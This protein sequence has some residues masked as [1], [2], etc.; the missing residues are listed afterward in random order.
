MEKTI[1]F[2]HGYL[3]SSGIWESIVTDVKA[4]C[5]CLDLLGHGANEQDDF[6]SISDMSLD[7]LQ[8][9]QERRVSNY[10]VVGHSMGGYVA[11]DLMERDPCC[12]KIMLLNS[13]FWED[14]AGKKKDRL[15]VVEAVKHNKNRFL[16]E[17][18][19]N[20]FAHP[21]DHEEEV[22]LLIREAAMMSVEAIGNASLAMRSRS[23][24]TDLVRSRLK[25]VVVV[26][27]EMDAVMPPEDMRE[28]IP[29]GVSF[30]LLPCGHMSWCEL[31]ME[32]AQLIQRY[33]A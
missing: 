3:E 24:R 27:G 16:Q 17:V 2:L 19:P 33:L 8:E 4:N 14:S 21:E 5:I 9:L 1:V 23:D 7:V 6:N 25:D 28:K 20:L 11:L 22:G 12:E 31:P 26:Q 10:S 13:N 29:E 15:R 18:I 32:T 30:E